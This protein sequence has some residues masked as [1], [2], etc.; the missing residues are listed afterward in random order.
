[1]RVKREYERAE[2]RWKLWLREKG[3]L[4]WTGLM[5]ERQRLGRSWAQYGVRVEGSES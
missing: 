4:V 1:M 5:E 3:I 2:L